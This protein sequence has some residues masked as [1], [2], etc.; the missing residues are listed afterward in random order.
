MPFNKVDAVLSNEVGRVALFFCSECLVLPPV[1]VAGAIN[2]GVKIAISGDQS[3]ELVEPLLGGKI[4]FLVAE[5][6]LPKHA[7]GVAVF[8]E[9]L[10]NRKCLLWQPGLLGCSAESAFEAAA[11][12]TL[13]HS[14]ERC[15][16][17]RRAH[18]PIRME[19]GEAQS[20]ACELVYIG[21]AA[22]R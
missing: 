5:M 10:R 22:R 19:I 20:A 4:R 17:S 21:G 3:P 11:K 2:T 18:G 8:S 13:I 12:S 1:G 7:R 16:P 9:K 14:C 15:R 6:P